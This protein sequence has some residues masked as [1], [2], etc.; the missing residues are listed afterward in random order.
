MCHKYEKRSKKAIGELKT[1]LK[2]IKIDGVSNIVRSSELGLTLF[3]IS[4][5]LASAVSCVFLILCSINEFLTFPV[6]TT[7]RL[8]HDQQTVFPV[9]TLCHR[10]RYWSQRA[11]ELF[12]EANISFSFDSLY[13]IHQLQGYEQNKTGHLLSDKRKQMLSHLDSALFKCSYGPY[14][15]NSSDFEWVWDPFFFGCYRFN[16]GRDANNKPVELRR[17]QMAG[18]SSRLSLTLYAGLPDAISRVNTQDSHGFYV[19]IGNQSHYPFNPFHQPML[20]KPGLSAEISIE[21]EFYEQFNVWPY[22][23]S[24]CRV[25]GDNELLGSG[26]SLFK[27]THLFD[28]V[29]SSNYSYSRSTCYIY[30][31]Q[32]YIVQECGCNIILIDYRAPPVDKF[33]IDKRQYDCAYNHLNIFANSDYAAH[34]CSDKCPLECANI[35]ERNFIKT[36]VFSPY[37]SAREVG[38]IQSKAEYIAKVGQ[39]NDFRNNLAINLVSFSVTYN[40]LA[41]TKI[42]E[43][44]QYSW[45]SLLGTI[46]GHLHLFLGMSLL[47]FVEILE[48]ILKVCFLFKS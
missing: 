28:E 24:E 46:G 18:L 9:V 45:E 33:C 5:A 43:K 42:D 13:M 35:N 2:L 20:I 14:A 21:R 1:D 34:N 17:A 44:A 39:Q 3:W 40:S 8:Y 4:I 15:C 19:F 12:A 29:V 22:K 30:C 10:N 47:S 37:P 27:D 36:F 31:A 32:E 41:Y 25:N 48:I 16:S 26:D 23:Y 11:V 7:I 38:L 6:S